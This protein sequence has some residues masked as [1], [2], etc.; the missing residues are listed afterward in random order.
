MQICLYFVSLEEKQ[1]WLIC[2]NIRFTNHQMLVFVSIL[3]ILAY[4]IKTNQKIALCPQ[5]RT[6]SKKIFLF[7]GNTCVV[8]T[9]KT[10]LNA[11]A[12]MFFNIFK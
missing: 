11:T 12:T 6:A 7:I 10:A 5:F 9:I 3:K 8:R 4:R 2:W 1:Y